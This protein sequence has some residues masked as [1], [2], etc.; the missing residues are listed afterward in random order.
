MKENKSMYIFDFDN[1]LISSDDRVIV[2][3]RDGRIL[4]FNATDI[5][6]YNPCPDDIIDSTQFEEYPTNARIIK[7]VFNVFIDR[8]NKLGPDSVFVLTARGKR[9]PVYQ[10]LIDNGSNPNI[11]VVAIGDFIPVAK[12]NYVKERLLLDNYD[13]VY[14]YEDSQLNID[15]VG[16]MVRNMGIN[17]YSFLVNHANEQDLK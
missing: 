10:Y 1:T 11:C 9:R 16:S 5:H 2:K 4:E 12:A 3:K 13:S 8:H 15:A 17:F 7:S 6:Y 14:L